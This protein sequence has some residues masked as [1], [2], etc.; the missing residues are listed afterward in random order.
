MS[1]RAKRAP[2][3]RVRRLR[4]P[5]PELKRPFELKA[6]ALTQISRPSPLRR[7]LISQSVK[8]EG[9]R[10]AELFQGGAARESPGRRRRASKLDLR[11]ETGDPSYYG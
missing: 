2:G 6:S 9:R 8:R 10:S 3:R 7:V 1:R 4:P 11:D 5:R